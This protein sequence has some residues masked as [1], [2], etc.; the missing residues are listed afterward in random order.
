MAYKNTSE[1]KKNNFISL[2]TKTAGK[3]R[4]IFF[5]NQRILEKSIFRVKFCTKISYFD[6]RKDKIE[7]SLA[8]SNAIFLYSFVSKPVLSPDGLRSSST[9][10]KA[11]NASRDGDRKIAKML[12]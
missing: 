7:R 3:K 11:S 1:P 4:K 2:S 6:I 12:I 5:G 9:S 8:M 10:N